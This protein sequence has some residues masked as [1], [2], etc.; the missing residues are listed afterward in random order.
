[1]E[2]VPEVQVEGDGQEFVIFKP[3]LD[4]SADVLVKFVLE[5]SAGVVVK[6]VLALCVA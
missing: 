4:R 1:L 5:L 3:V 2:A 6:C